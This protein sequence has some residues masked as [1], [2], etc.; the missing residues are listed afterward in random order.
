[1]RA[2]TF[3]KGLAQMIEDTAR[4]ADLPLLRKPKDHAVDQLVGAGIEA[5]PDI[6]ELLAHVPLSIVFSGSKLLLAVLKY[7]SPDAVGRI[8]TERRKVINRCFKG[9]FIYRGLVP[10]DEELLRQRR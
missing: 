6:I 7:V 4:E 1:L 8:E 5:T 10:L 3:M 9:N 2:P